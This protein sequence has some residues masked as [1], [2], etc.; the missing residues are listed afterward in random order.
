[1]EIKNNVVVVG[2]G[3]IGSALIEPLCRWVQ[4]SVDS[5]EPITVKLVDGD[6]YEPKNLERQRMVWDDV[7]KNKAEVHARNLADMFDGL[8]IEAVPEYVN[9]TNIESIIEDGDVVMIGV[10]NHVTRK[11]IADYC[12]TL[13]N[14]TVISGGNELTDGNVIVFVREEGKNLTANLPDYH[15]EIQNP[16]DKHPEDLSCEDLLEV[17]PQLLFM[18]LQIAT[19]MLIALYN[20]VE[21]E[22]DWSE[23]GEIYTDIKLCK[24]DTAERNPIAGKAV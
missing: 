5:K 23:F 19:L 15:P 20:L 16:P 11:M 21:H 18:N 24:T 3:G 12:Q 2:V 13:D 22:G 8:V 1:M 14:V 4:F 10:D 17:H 7:R 6:V 9:E